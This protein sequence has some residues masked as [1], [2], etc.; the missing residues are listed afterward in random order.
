MT[1][2]QVK[3]GRKALLLI[4]N[5]R[6]ITLV[7]VLV[8]ILAFSGST[9]AQNQANAPA[10][11]TRFDHWSVEQGLITDQV[12]ALAQDDQGYMWIG[13]SAGLSR[14]DGHKFTHFTV[15]T[16][17][18]EIPADVVTALFVDRQNRLWIGTDNGLAIRNLA[19]GE[20]VFH[21]FD[22]NDSTSPSHNAIR[23]IVESRQGDIWVGTVS[24]LNLFNEMRQ[25]F[26]RFL[27]DAKDPHSLPH[28]FVK[29]LFFD[30]QDRLY[31]ATV[32]K[33]VSRFDRA[34]KQ[35]IT[36][37]S[38]FGEGIIRTI[39]IDDRDRLWIGSHPT[40][41][42][43]IDLA[44]G[45]S[46]IVSVPGEGNIRDFAQDAS[47][48]IWVATYDSGISIY[49]PELALQ[50]TVAPSSQH[51]MALTSSAIAT[52]LL[53]RDG[54]MWVGSYVSG[55]F[56]RNPIASNIGHLVSD[57][58]SGLVGSAFIDMQGRLWT[59]GENWLE[60]RTSQWPHTPLA[61]ASIPGVIQTIKQFD[62]HRIL[63]G[64]TLGIYIVK[65]SG[66]NDVSLKIEAISDTQSL[67]VP[68]IL[69]QQGHLIAATNQ[70]NYW[71]DIEKR[72]LRKIVFGEQQPILDA[73]ERY[74][75]SLAG[76]GKRRVWFGSFYGDVYEMDT[77]SGETRLLFSMRK[78]MN[79]ISPIA[80][81]LYW[82]ND[83]L[84]IGTNQGIIVHHLSSG[85]ESTI[86]KA[87][88]LSGMA[89][90]GISAAGDKIVI[91][92]NKG[93]NIYNEKSQVIERVLGPQDGLQESDFL[94]KV[95]EVVNSDCFIF[96]G[97]NGFNHLCPHKIP[98]AKGLSPPIL[99]SLIVN[100]QP[101]SS[102]E[103]LGKWSLNP[104][105]ES[106]G[107]TFRHSDKHIGLAF[108]SIDYSQNPHL[109]FRYRLLG[110][111]DDW[112]EL[113]TEARRAHYTSLP[114]G[115]Y[116]FQV[117]VLNT[118]LAHEK[119]QKSVAIKVLPPPWLT[120]WAY[121][122]YLITIILILW[123]AYFLRTR[124][125]L[126]YTAE[127]EG[128]VKTRTQ[129]ISLQA[130][131]IKQQRN[132]I[133]QALEEKENLLEEKE[134][135]FE[136]ISHELRT[137]VTL[138]NVLLQQL[139]VKPLSNGDCEVVATMSRSTQRLS[140][141]VEDIIELSKARASIRPTVKRLPLAKLTAAVVDYLCP[142]AG[143]RGVTI[144]TDIAA[145]LA[146]DAV[147]KEIVLMLRNLVKNSILH[148]DCRTIVV[149]ARRHGAELVLSVKDDGKGIP[150]SEQAYIFERF[151]RV[152]CATAS[153][154]SGLGLAL[155]KQVVE[156]HSGHIEVH[157]SE[158]TGCEFVVQLPAAVELENA[159]QSN[160][161]AL[162]LSADDFNDVTPAPPTF[163]P[164]VAPEARD[165]AMQRER[166]LVVEDEPELC[167]AL[168]GVLGESFLVDTARNGEEGLA[169]A[170]ELLPDLVVTDLRM[171]KRDGLQ[172]LQAIKQDTL[173]CHIP[174]ILL[175]A[176]D[177]DLV[178]LSSY[179]HSAD[180]FLPKPFEPQ[181]LL[182]II[183]SS[184]NNRLLTRQHTLQEFLSKRQPA[185]PFV[186]KLDKLIEQKL[187][188]ANTNVE[189]LA[190]K[191]ALS[192]Q[193]FY[194]KVSAETGLTPKEYLRRHRL[195]YAKLLLEQGKRVEIV[196]ESCGYRDVDAFRRHFKQSFGLT[197]KQYQ[198]EHRRAYLETV[199]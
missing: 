168:A 86:T 132:Q 24:G 194:R 191:M 28:P 151:Y 121:A 109:E 193:Q 96:G 162:R 165:E 175:T 148:A 174:V 46:E 127:L 81:M 146:V 119:K 171:P 74:F 30:S 128:A 44:S 65:H 131:K 116:T 92:A 110:F 2:K 143:G 199:S 197:P 177:E 130:S 83:R 189:V 82:L 129:E 144:D 138:L 155:V 47:G 52:L 75:V 73:N 120:P 77:Q 13:T 169:K 22:D 145:T 79:K 139:A 9:V 72:S 95:D 93:I 20:T 135:L 172:L 183:R 41:V 153:A 125:I 180:H 123:C 16:S 179:Q 192:R 4:A 141:M 23:S 195:E 66:P 56:R 134:S 40:Q 7:V 147:E 35:F 167:R 97:F 51:R 45:V 68:D 140:Q 70:G 102:F 49:T 37:D 149:A 58:H 91:S 26:T 187:D 126:R 50:E 154:G 117:E 55:I 98:K 101:I 112:V 54:D 173:T 159:A 89:I 196:I 32:G 157:S 94:N 136:Q 67:T 166:I 33:G 18:S 164:R 42:K 150:K 161:Y 100:Y 160:G 188:D 113:G 142:L 176:V 108:T 182:S 1:G 53:D 133:K 84:Y 12:F 43:I 11:P 178:K 99:E 115:S 29:Q 15:D 71:V 186:Q 105:H 57:T 19:S 39:F 17:P 118:L 85:D 3:S 156:N 14:F 76:D 90:G 38:D 69:I 111:D 5:V 59:G 163:A 170:I 124:Q 21:L 152:H 6:A 63:V 185:S 122:I 181:E 36:I 78:S 80:D 88:G 103:Q 104:L 158:G 8:L 114:A 25:N 184:L 31:V 48:Y 60:V 87:H 137:P 62:K 27:H 198:Q 10:Y 107:L 61:T 190:G 106:T 64:T 34:R